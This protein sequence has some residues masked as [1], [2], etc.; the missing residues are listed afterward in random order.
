MFLLKT[1]KLDVDG[2][3]EIVVEFLFFKALY[4]EY[5]PIFAPISQNI[6]SFFFQNYL[7]ILKF[8]VLW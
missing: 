5:K 8:L 1:L 7:S 6:K 4:I 3:N 2:S